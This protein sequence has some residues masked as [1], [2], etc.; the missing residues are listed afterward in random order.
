MNI[1]IQTYWNVETLYYVLNAVASVMTSGGWPGLIKFVF[2]VALLIAMFAYMGRH[3]DM[4]MWFIQAFA[5]VTILNMPIAR[6]MLSDRTDLQPPRQV[7]HVPVALAAIAQASSLSFGFLTRAYETAFNVPDDL[8]LAKG[9]VGFGHRILRQVNSAVVRD[10]AL[11]ADLMQFF[12]ECTKY[13][14]LDG[15]IAPSQIVGA[16]D[17]WNT[18]FGDT[19]PARFVTYNVLTSQPV[20]DTCQNVALVLKPR[21]DAAVADAQAFYGRK[22]FPQASS[23]G[24]A[25]QMF[26]STVSTS[27]SWLLDA[28]QSASDAMKQAMFN[29]IWRD[30][31]PG[32]AR[33][34]DDP[35]A[36]ADTN[37]LI[38][39]AEAARQANGSNSAL[40][41]LGQETIPHMRN[42]IE[43]ITYALFPV[44][45]LLMIVVPQEKAKYVLGGYFMILVWIG[46]WPLLFA[47]IN[48]L[49]LMWLHYK[50][51]ALHLSAGVPFQLSSAFDSTLVDEQAMIGYMVVLVPFIAGAIVKMG[52][53][54]IFGLADR[55][56]SGFAAAGSRAGAAIASGNFSMGQA[57]LDTA[58][59]NT[60]TMQK[61][62]GNMLMNSG[63]RTVQLSDGSTM[64]VSSNGRAAYQKLA[65]HLLTSMQLEDAQ[66]SGHSFD[67]FSGTTSTSGWSSSTRSGSSVGS[68]ESFGHATERGATQS[69]GSE[70]A[71]TTSGGTNGRAMHDESVGR[72]NQIGTRFG[73]GIGA[74]DSIQL[75]AGGS[76]HLGIDASQGGATPRAPG[77]GASERD[78]RRVANAMKQG[79]ASAEQIDSA[80]QNMRGNQ[81]AEG[82]PSVRRGGGASLS[83]GAQVTGI[84]NYTAGHDRD[85]SSQSDHRTGD[86]VSSGSEVSQTGSTSARNATGTQSSQSDRHDSSATR[87]S[88]SESAF[89]REHGVHSETGSRSTTSDGSSMRFAIERNLAEDPDFMMKVGQRNHVSATRMW[90]MSEEKLIGMAAEYLDWKAMAQ[91]MR[92]PQGA[93]ANDDAVAPKLS[94]DFGSHRAG[95]SS[96]GQGG[97][98][99]A[100]GG[101]NDF[102]SRVKATGFSSTDPV[103]PNMTAPT[104][105][106]AA[107]HALDQ[108]RHIG[109]R[110]KDFDADVHK[111]ASPD[112]ALGEGRVT[113]TEVNAA[114][115]DRD[116]ADTVRRSWNAPR[117]ALG[118]KEYDDYDT[119]DVPPEIKK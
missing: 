36:I 64:S 101:A 117:R 52:D 16:T 66:N 8:G 97:G 32:I 50:L 35:A 107:Q 46:L 58:S 110:A 14:I 56:L 99:H 69:I 78:A 86:S 93:G 18:I 102:G 68:S 108:G 38:A 17:T 61:F 116:L 54:A 70:T 29:N 85:W 94:H 112:R 87:S 72:T 111:H 22:A 2:L 65:N 119:K 91:N 28:S 83:L 13:D 103:K 59:V 24:I 41:L 51:T 75:H 6:V 57:G 5:F 34:H 10:P 15:A 42:W 98:G 21:V 25:Q 79:G 118:M 89:Q 92:G 105:I 31:G 19:S 20:T 47:I 96:R 33:A 84:R 76:G 71:T 9:D 1:E 55:A 49:S 3:G 11:R 27:Y 100:S 74:T 63:M 48:H 53:G 104:E 80:M 81:A 40:S 26:L 30:A 95:T 115:E 12:K 82:A 106:S 109:Q 60:T 23:D 67:R 43:A 62:D 39:E 7:D 113:Q 77:A 4:A 114:N 37:A 88:F 45:V 73:T 90:Q 44:M